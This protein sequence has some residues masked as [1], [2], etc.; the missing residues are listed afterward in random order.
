MIPLQKKAFEAEL[1]RLPY[2]RHL[3]VDATTA[4]IIHTLFKDEV[5][6]VFY[7]FNMIDSETRSKDQTQHAIYLLDPYRRYSIDCLNTDYGRGRRYNSATIMFLP[8]SYNSAWEYLMQNPNFSSAFRGKGPLITYSLGV[9]PSE[10]HL[11]VTGAYPSIPAYYSQRENAKELKEYQIEKAVNSMVSICIIFNELPIIRYYNSPVSA[12]LAKRLQHSLMDYARNNTDFNPSSNRTTFMITDRTM[13]MFDALCHY[14]Y[15]RYFVYDY[16][17][18]MEM[19]PG[20]YPLMSYRYNAITRSNERVENEVV[21]STKDEVYQSLKD[22]SL[23]EVLSGLKKYSN[24]IEKETK[25]LN[26]LQ[27][28]EE[29]EKSWKLGKLTPQE[30]QRLQ[31]LRKVWNVSQTMRDKMLIEKHNQLKSLVNGHI[32]FCNEIKDTKK[33]GMLREYE[34]ICAL[35]IGSPKESSHLMSPTE[36]LLQCLSSLSDED[37]FDKVRLILIYTLS[38][39]GIIRSDMR[40]LVMF[41]LPNNVEKIMKNLE[42]LDGMG[43]QI[44]KENLK[45]KTTPKTFFATKPDPQSSN[46]VKSFVP[47]YCNIIEKLANGTLSENYTTTTQMVNGYENEIDPSLMTFPYANAGEMQVADSM[48]YNFESK[49]KFS[50]TGKQRPRMFIFAAGGLTASELSMIGSM[51]EKINHDIY[52]G[53]DQIY[54]VLDMIG[55]MNE[56]NSGELQFELHEKQKQI[57]PP[58][59][60]ADVAAPDPSSTAASNTNSSSVHQK[61]HFHL[62]GTGKSNG[63]SSVDGKDTEKKKR[64]LFGKLKHI[65]H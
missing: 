28:M 59:Y 23:P 22:K 58:M 9:S 31:D 20:A 65:G 48:A 11:F 34:A 13:S 32:N 61:S 62:P 53:T 1:S 52:I 29:L 63:R 26:Q 49:L 10:P 15:Y 25:R 45:V 42:L 60:L 39:G 30:K 36:G 40:K 16:V 24:D 14:D 18:N 33:L 35:F 4:P 56:M 47:S 27:E 2:P 51:E 64:G 50:N 54:S 6:N 46:Y 12:A 57:T 17:L 21:F 7:T 5:L 55:D 44:F 41:S 43:L 3:I 38:R 37:I 8:G 19:E